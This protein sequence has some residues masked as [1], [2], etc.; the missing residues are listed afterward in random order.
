MFNDEDLLRFTTWIVNQP[1][2]PDSGFVVS[3][4]EHAAKT[5]TVLWAGPSTAFLAKIVSEADARGIGLAVRQVKYSRAD[6]ARGC[7][8]IFDATTT[9]AAIG[10][11]LS[12]VAC[13]DLTH[14]GLTVRGFDPRAP[15]DRL[16]DRL[17]RDVRS[18]LG[19]LP[20]LRSSIDL[21]DVRIGYGQQVLL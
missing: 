4:D 10:F 3:A 12:G 8:A 9:L 16:D 17:V 15:A 2:Y 6:L 20:D 19:R 5:K 7:Q 13:S 14:D 18:A 1:E 11:Q 21:A